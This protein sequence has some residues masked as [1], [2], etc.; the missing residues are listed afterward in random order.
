MSFLSSIALST[1]GALAQGVLWGIMV[2]GVYITYKLLD[3]P[4]L[5]ADGSFTLGG[6]V[7]TV[8]ILGGINPILATFLGILAGA[9]AGAVTGILHTVFEIPAILAGILTQIGLW[10]VNL[11]I[12][13][14]KANNPLLK[15]TSIISFVAEKT[16]LT[17]SQSSLIVGIVLA[18]AV[19]L[20]LYWFFGTEIGSALRATGD[21]PDMIR[22]LGVNIGHTKLIALSLSNALIGFSG[23]MVA[24]MQKYAD[25]NMGRG[26][27]VIGLA[28]IVIG[29]VLLRRVKNFGMKLTSAVIGSMVYF[30]IQAYVLKMGLDPN[31]MKLLSALLVALALAIPVAA[32]KYRQKRSYVE[33]DLYAEQRVQAEPIQKQ[34]GEDKTGG[35][36]K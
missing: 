26:A 12:M 21:N 11:R 3:I 34:N 10:S 13:G 28:A 25:I 9:A 32:S 14:G 30:V 18:A 33:Y 20:L 5:T 16:G 1:Q 23:A 2:L 19:I 7:C 8:A 31:D 24:Q 15:T 22:A 6:C 35:S 29:E 27:I 17:Q 4:D 36:V